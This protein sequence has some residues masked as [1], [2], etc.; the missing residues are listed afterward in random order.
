MSTNRLTRRSRAMAESVSVT[1]SAMAVPRIPRPGASQTAIP[2]AVTNDPMYTSRSHPVRP[3]MIRMN[4]TVPTTTGK[5]N[6]MIRIRSA[7]RP[8][9][10]ASPYTRM[11]V[12]GRMASA[13]RM[14][15][16]VASPHRVTFL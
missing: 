3:T 14:G 6:P 8:A 7:E 12:P 15:T 1:A 13:S 4:P 5:I 9:T 11:I 2:T 10:K 16:V